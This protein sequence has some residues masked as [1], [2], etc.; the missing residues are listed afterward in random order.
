[1][2]K[3]DVFISRKG[4]DAIYAKQIY[5]YLSEQ[6]LVVFDS[7]NTLKQLGNANYIK[8]IDEALINS[9][10]M[11]VVGSSEENIKAS[12]VESE[13]L[14]FLNR[15]RSGKASGNLFTVIID[16]FN[17]ADVPPSLANYEVITFNKKN[18]PI[19]YNYVRPH[20]SSPKD[21]NQNQTDKDVYLKANKSNYNNIL[22]EAK[23]ENKSIINTKTGNSTRSFFSAPLTILI[24][25]MIAVIGFVTFYISQK[26]V[27]ATSNVSDKEITDYILEMANKPE[28]KKSLT[29]YHSGFSGALGID[30]KVNLIYRFPISEGDSF[31]LRNEKFINDLLFK[32]LVTAS[33][34]RNDVIGDVRYKDFEISLTEKGKSILIGETLDAY[35]LSTFDLGEIEIVSK[36]QKGDTVFASI[37]MKSIIKKT[38]AFD[39]MSDDSKAELDKDLKIISPAVFLKTESGLKVIPM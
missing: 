34:T 7:D 19:I 22:E 30:K 15:K 23:K 2:Q 3:F 25:I 5:D 4:T 8:A 33:V 27:V 6:G 20:N 26:N 37:R 36:T 17:I 14:F 10:H 31:N 16:G 1:M 9:T 35:Y 39:V 29:G 13:W 21:L 32:G 38:D 28:Q 18:F 11:I 24:V 12:W